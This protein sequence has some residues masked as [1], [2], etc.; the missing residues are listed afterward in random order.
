MVIQIAMKHSCV[1]KW[2]V[3]ILCGLCL[4]CVKNNP[5]TP[6][7]FFEYDPL[8]K[9]THSIAA[10]RRL[11][12]QYD[13]LSVNQ[14][15]LLK[16][17]IIITGIVSADD[18]SGNLY[19]Q[20]MIQ[21]DSAAICVKIDGNN[22]YNDFPRG[23]RIYIQCNG[24]WLGFDGGLP[25]LGYEPDEQG[26]PIPI[27]E[28]VLRDKVIK[29]SMGHNTIADTIPASLFSIA[30]PRWYNKLVCIPEV[31]FKDIDLNFTYPTSA[32]S[33]EL[34]DCEGNKFITR[35][36]AYADF[37]ASKLPAGKGSIAGIYTVY[38]NNSGRITP[39]L[40]LRDTHDI[41]FT[42]PRCGLLQG[43]TL[44]YENFE[45]ANTTGDLL[46]PGWQNISVQENGVLFTC[47]E[48]GGTRYARVSGF[49]SQL[50]EINTW[51]ISPE[52]DPGD[53]QNL[54]L[55][56]Y[57][58][59]GY[60][61]GAELKVFLCTSYSGNPQTTLWLP[62]NAVISKG[63]NQGYGQNWL[64]SGYIPLPVNGQ[65]FRVGFQYKGADP[66]GSAQDKTT[67]YQIDDIIVGTLK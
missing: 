20:I 58:I 55:S 63:H 43:K 54:V 10:L 61:N 28:V 26:V 39:Q 24:L 44:L 21:D 64:H 5:D 32:T 22:I 11:Q 2:I 4:S 8:L 53:L 6:P 46:L 31:Q 36:S 7:L 9:S 40:M 1:S 14:S 30:D 17:S 59:D 42:L 67:T 25:V 62:L 52:I 65:K 23:R 27:P 3:W 45:K 49:N 19:K 15:I 41:Q 18:K 47:A 57:T 50:P 35:N 34:E 51:L 37:A 60:D 16:E 56:F 38:I 48:F 13:P 66:S 29:G 33:R 12:N